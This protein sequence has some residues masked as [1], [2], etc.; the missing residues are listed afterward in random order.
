MGHTGCED[1]NGHNTLSVTPNRLQHGLRPL[2]D[3]VFLVF[4][5]VTAICEEYG[6]VFISDRLIRSFFSTTS[7]YFVLS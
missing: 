2:V 4:I 7:E 3:I 5:L 6:I 1:S